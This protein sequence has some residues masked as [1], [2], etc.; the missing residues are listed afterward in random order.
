M[1]TPSLKHLSSDA[2]KR[3]IFILVGSIVGILDYVVARPGA[4]SDPLDS[5]YRAFAVTALLFIGELVLEIRDKQGGDGSPHAAF[6]ARNRNLVG[7]ILK[8]LDKQLG[9]HIDL[10][11]DEFSVHDV[12]LPIMSHDVFWQCLVDRAIAGQELTVLA[13]HSC[14][15]DVWLKNPDLLSHQK[16]FCAHGGKVRRVLCDRPAIPDRTAIEAAA[17][18]AAIRID[19]VKYYEVSPER[20]RDYGFTWDFAVVQQTGEAA[21]WRSRASGGEIV[22]AIYVGGNKYGGR[23]LTEFW[24]KLYGSARDIPERESPSA[25]IETS[26]A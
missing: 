22:E 6:I 7:A 16:T 8:R 2:L 24:N 23:I 15:M 17:A 19:D 26:I 14:A 4:Q 1:A 25:H 9:L 10:K 13:V 18:M 3:V 11:H 20:L 21:I 12:T 5:L